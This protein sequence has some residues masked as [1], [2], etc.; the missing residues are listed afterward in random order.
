MEKIKALVLLA[1]LFSKHGY[2]LY[3]VGGSVRDYL[4]NKELDD[5]DVVSDAT[6]S[7]VM[8]FLEVKD[9]TFKRFGALKILYE[10][11]NFDF[12]TLRKENSYQDYRHPGEIVFT[13]DLKED[14]IRRDI[15]I[16]ALYL[17]S[18]LEVVDLVNGVKD[19]NNHIIRI[20][21][22]KDIRIKEDP[23]RIVR[24]L[25][26]SLDLDFEIEEESKLAIYNNKDLINKLNIEKI[27]SEINKCKHKEKLIN[28]LKDMNNSLKI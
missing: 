8:S 28:L 5:M 7:E 26:F 10:G 23:L 25:R 1:D 6:P 2:S 24:I 14:V 21:G 15:S 17:S 18:S 12:T 19:L 22:N 27:K 11:V 4:L 20:I 16:N 3:L 9:D 13:K